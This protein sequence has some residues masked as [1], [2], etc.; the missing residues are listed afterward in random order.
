MLRATFKIASAEY[1]REGRLRFTRRADIILRYYLLQ[2]GL[3]DVK[4]ELL[5][6]CPVENCHIIAAAN[7]Q[8]TRASGRALLFNCAIKSKRF[9]IISNK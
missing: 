8:R 4:I 3:P 7:V 9:I 2:T 1:R 6:I 5:I